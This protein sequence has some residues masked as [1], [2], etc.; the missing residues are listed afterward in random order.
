MAV[1]T[2]LMAS[3]TRSNRRAAR[4]ATTDDPRDAPPHKADHEGTTT[5]LVPVARTKRL[6]STSGRDTD[7]ADAPASKR[8]KTAGLDSAPPKHKNTP[9]SQPA[10]APR[11][12][13]TQ[14]PHQLNAAA[15]SQ[16]DTQKQP[17]V[18]RHEPPP[19]KVEGKPDAKK[20]RT[21]STASHASRGTGTGSAAPPP[22]KHRTKS[23]AIVSKSIQHELD[24]LQPSD[25]DSKEKPGGRKLRSQEATRF[26]SE[27][28]A[29][30]PD[31]DE[32]IGNDPKEQHLLNFD[33]P[34]VVDDS[35]PRLFQGKVVAPL[36]TEPLPA[37]DGHDDYPIRGY[38]DA[39]FS[40]LFDAQ[41][42]DFDFL[43]N[44][45]KG[46]TLDDP[47][48]DELYMPVHRKAER[49]ERSIRNTEKGR[50][51]HE[52]DQIIRILEGLQGH[53]WL[54]IMGVSG[55]TE[56]RKKSFEPARLHF[57]KG[58][59]AIIDKFR[60]WGLAEKR[61]K[62][63]KERALAER[64]E[65]DGNDS[66]EDDVA[67]ESGSDEEEVPDSDDDDDDSAPV[68][69][70]DVEASIAKQLRQ[71]AAAR[72]RI[73]ARAGRKRARTPPPPKPAP[74]PREFK[75]FF[76]KKHERD[77]ALNPNRRS[78]RRVLAWGEPLPDMPQQEFMLPEE[79]LDPETMKA[80][81]RKRRRQRRGSRH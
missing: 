20:P 37:D 57:I 12:T 76:K 27:L 59:Q 78:G 64:A 79:F 62:A 53:D 22:T 55:V 54:R 38:G 6:L 45:Y 46:K 30:F 31:Y 42:I 52:K 18:S 63:E 44:S 70:N 43:G 61:R 15:S 41:R 60:Q 80:H 2:A 8:Q 33:T 67:V 10:N 56:S 7:L 9:R 1:Q 3:N 49:L 75:S 74:P 39:L 48:A 4:N 21:S 32:V 11:P 29:Y 69:E 81:A 13:T 28:S 23:A 5:T 73:A 65:Q 66:D 71:E 34:I 50:A 72:S 14:P 19:Q 26:K 16:P 40:D 58:C 24:R 36:F 35:S 77:T 47:L 25:A 17:Q 51:Q 68:D